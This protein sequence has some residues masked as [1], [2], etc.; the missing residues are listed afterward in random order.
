MFSSLNL[1][2]RWARRSTL[3][4]PASLRVEVCP[5]SL[6]FA[7]A[8][9][10]WQ[11]ALFWLM[12]PAP[13]QAAAVPQRLPE[14]RRDFMAVLADIDGDDADALRQRLHE[15]RT[16][17]ELWHARAEVY[18]VVGVAHNQAAA[19]ERIALLNGHFPTRSPRSQLAPL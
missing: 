6:C 8:G 19:E 1:T 10:V 3:S 4:D 18:R 9:G 13:H 14:V 16:L 17:R 12:A 7:P 5:P 11:R 15:A 2:G